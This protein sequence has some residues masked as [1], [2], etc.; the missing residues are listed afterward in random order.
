LKLAV[1]LEHQERGVFGDDGI[2]FAEFDD[3][4]RDT[5][6]RAGAVGLLE[7]AVDSMRGPH[8]IDLGITRVL[9]REVEFRGLFEFHA[10]NAAAERNLRFAAAGITAVNPDGRAVIQIGQGAWFDVVD[11]QATEIE[12]QIGRGRARELSAEGL[13]LAR[14]VI[15]VR[16]KRRQTAGVLGELFEQRLV[17][18][19]ADPDAEDLRAARTLRD[20]LEKQ[21]TRVEEAAVEMAQIRE[22]D[23][24]VDP[25]PESPNAVISPADRNL[26]AIELDLNT[27]RTRVIKIE[28]A[29][30]QINKMKP[31]EL[32]EVL[33]TLQIDDQ[34]VIKMVEN[35]QIA[36]AKEA[37]LYASG[38]G[39]RHPQLN[40][41]HAQKEVFR[42]ILADALTSVIQNQAALL[43]IEHRTLEH[44]QA[45]FEEAL[46]KQIEDKKKTTAYIDAKT[47]YL[48]SKKIFE[49]AQIKYSTELL[50][51][52][53]DFDPAKIWEKAEPSSSFA[54]PNVP[55]YVALSAVIGLVLGVGLA[56]FIELLIQRIEWLDK[57][58]DFQSFAENGRG[59]CRQSW[60][61]AKARVETR[62]SL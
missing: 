19:V 22:R 59:H 25:D 35:L 41:W 30:E 5:R 9:L 54:K 43:Q 2:A 15:A 4:V 26:V 12:L 40:S 8:A 42:K 31:E 62:P 34:N 11:L 23:N 58:S 53:I 14:E 21:R 61:H 60:I 47:K 51:K 55:A 17:H 36:T 52:G 10:T 24:I 45:K 7:E 49:A 27:Q 33:R 46:G 50:E 38:L 32:R 29:F 48:Q 28:G 6:A 16:D 13:G 57:A 1:I 3:F 18:I 56:F 44:L 39:E 20:E 37:E